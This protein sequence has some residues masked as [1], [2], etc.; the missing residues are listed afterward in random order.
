MVQLFSNE[1]KRPDTCWLNSCLKSKFQALN[2]KIEGLHKQLAGQA[3]VLEER[4]RLARELH[5]SVTQALYG[6]SLNTA[7]AELALANGKAEAV[8][9]NLQEIR[10]AVQEAGSETRVLLFELRPP[11]LEETGTGGSA[12]GAASFS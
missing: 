9:A 4:H 7:A 5:A 12:R 3:A 11:L 8:A 2:L 6:V 1:A 10:E